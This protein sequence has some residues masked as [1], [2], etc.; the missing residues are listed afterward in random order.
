MNYGTSIGYAFTVP[1]DKGCFK[2]GG[3]GHYKKGCPENRGMDRQPNH[4]PGI[5]PQSKRGSN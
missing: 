3:T 2:C 5:C 4:S 1:G